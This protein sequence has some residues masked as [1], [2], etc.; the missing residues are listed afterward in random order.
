MRCDQVQRAMSERDSS[1]PDSG[2]SRAVLRHLENC[3]ECRAAGVEFDRLDRML[4]G[5]DWGDPP[6][7]LYAGVHDR[8]SAIPAPG[9]LAHLWTCLS[10]RPGQAL[11]LTAALASVVAALV[12]PVPRPGLPELEVHPGARS[13]RTAGAL[14]HSIRLHALAATHGNPED[15]IAW[16]A[17]AL[18]LERG[19]RRDGRPAGLPRPIA[20]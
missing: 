4:R 15:R 11:G 3:S 18:L 20:E 14:A 5:Y 16:E 12:A 10:G 6:A 17:M 1:R 7:S 2:L 8:V 13:G 19:Q 9:R